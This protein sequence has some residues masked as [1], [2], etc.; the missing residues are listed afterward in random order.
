VPLAWSGSWTLSCRAGRHR[1]EQGGIVAGESILIVD[2]NEM[3]LNSCVGCWKSMDTPCT[4]PA[5]RRP[6]ER[7]SGLSSPAGVDGHPARTWTVLQLTREFKADPQLRRFSRGGHLVRDERRPRGAST[8]DATA[9][10]R[11]QSTA[12]VPGGDPEVL[13]RGQR[14]ELNSRRI[15]PED[16]FAHQEEIAE[17]TAAW[18]LTRTKVP[19][20]L[21]RSLTTREPSPTVMVACLLETYPSCGSSRRRA[22][23]HQLS[24]T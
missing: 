8:P 10:S 12:A 14:R 19:L 20:A 15:D 11:S 16:L 6:R 9:T 17:V 1:T 4:Q 3:N 21:P 5:T 18:P 13:R 2:D 7:A 22:A 24:P 23:A